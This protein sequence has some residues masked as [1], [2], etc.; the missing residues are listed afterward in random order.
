ML[1]AMRT[2]AFPKPQRSLRLFS[3][4]NNLQFASV[5]ALVMF[6]VLLT[7]L[8]ETKPFHG[9]GPDLPKVLH[10]VSMPGANREDA[11]RIAVTRDGK[12]YFGS[13]QVETSAISGK[14]K[15]RLKDRYVERKVYITADARTYWK[16]VNLVLQQV[17]EAE[18]LRVV[19]LVDQRRI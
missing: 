16:T 13:A 5:M 1:S 9:F 3:D 7:F 19:F 17:R 2:A 8:V 14:L 18:I 6:A 11:T 10:P 12:V 4:F 15:D